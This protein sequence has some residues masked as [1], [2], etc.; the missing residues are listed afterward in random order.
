M[1]RNIIFDW[2]GTLVDDLPAVWSA[3][4]YVL[5][6]A[7]LPELSLDQFRAEFCLPFTNFYNRLTPHITIEQLELWFHARFKEVQA[8]V[9]ELPHARSFLQFCRKRGLRCFL[10][11]TIHNDHYTAQTAANGFDAFLE[12]PYTQVWN[13]REKIHQVLDENA[14]APNETL[15][16]GDMEHDIATAKHGGVRSC[17]V[18]TGYNTLAQLKAAAPD[19]IVEHLGELQRVL[20]ERASWI[21]S[22][23]RN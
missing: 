15:F 16:V 7:G 19:L 6:Q 4:N 17:A 13:K 23:L 12:R 9:V 18:L 20:E 21:P 5:S 22:S 10:L 11:S 3:T 14:L 8:S 2:S 1:I